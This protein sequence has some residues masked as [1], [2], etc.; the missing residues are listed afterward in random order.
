MRRTIREKEP[1]R[2]STRISTLGVEELTTAAKRRGLEAPKLANVLRGDLDWIVMKC[3]EKDR[4]RRYETANGLAM[5]IQRHLNGEPVVARRPSKVYQFQKLVRRNRLV[6]LAAAAVAVALVLGLVTSTWEAIRARR[7]ERAQNRLRLEA[8]RAQAGE[9]RQRAVA[10]QHLYDALLG[11]A[12]ARQLT[13]R[14]GQRF[15]SL[16]AITKAATVRRSR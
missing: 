3:L 14:A 2:P 10:E 4:T 9:A 16:E 11:E 15:E 8:E 7:A 13:G 1:A 5:D 12:S 6:F